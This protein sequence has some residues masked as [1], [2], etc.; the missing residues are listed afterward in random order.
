MMVCRGDNLNPAVR[1][2][3]SDLGHQAAQE[4]ERF[5]KIYDL[6][7]DR[8]NFV[9]IYNAKMTRMDE[10]SAS[11]DSMISTLEELVRDLDENTIEYDYSYAL[12]NYICEI[13]NTI[14]TYRHRLEIIKHCQI[15]GN[16]LRGIW[17]G[18]KNNREHKRH[19]SAYLRYGKDL[20]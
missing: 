20:I 6:K 2:S 10:V 4:L 13:S 17:R 5:I 11:F 14:N 12:G 15:N 19:E 3:F 16:R 18:L 9:D 8:T 7:F 1:K